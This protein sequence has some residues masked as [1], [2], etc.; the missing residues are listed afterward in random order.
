VSG[1]SDLDWAR[2][3]DGSRSTRGFSVFL[4]SNHVSWSVMKQTTVPRSSTEAEYKDLANT[5]A[6]I[7]WILRLHSKNLEYKDP[8]VQ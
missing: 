6:E 1:F 2:S 4:G 7:M 8:K 3:I 5:L